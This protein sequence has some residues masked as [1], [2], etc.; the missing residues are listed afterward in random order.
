MARPRPSRRHSATCGR[1]SWISWPALPGWL[2]AMGG[3]TVTPSPSPARAAAISRSG[4]SPRSWRLRRAR[5]ADPRRSVSRM[6]GLV[7]VIFGALAIGLVLV[8][9]VLMAR[10][11]TMA[12]ERSDVWKR[13]GWRDDE[14]GE[15]HP[16]RKDS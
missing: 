7:L 1:Q 10:L 4:R 15:E 5:T 12:A 8:G 16:R 9:G 14:G 13:Y 11:L 3:A 2:C 6:L